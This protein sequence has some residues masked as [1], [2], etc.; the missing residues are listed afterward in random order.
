MSSYRKASCTAKDCHRPLFI[1]T[2]CIWDPTYTHL[3]GLLAS[4]GVS[5]Y[6]SRW[7]TLLHKLSRKNTIIT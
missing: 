3:R 4:R 6:V 5:E 7:I 1:L 2:V